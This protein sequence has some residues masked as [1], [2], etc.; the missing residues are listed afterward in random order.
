M[1][2]ILG[3]ILVFCLGIVFVVIGKATLEH[4]AS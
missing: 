4:I 2:E 3:V 1:K